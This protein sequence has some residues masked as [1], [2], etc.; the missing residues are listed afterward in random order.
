MD[1]NQIRNASFDDIVFEG[2]NKQYGAYELRKKYNVRLLIAVIFAG[3]LAALLMVL[4]L[5]FGRPDEKKKETKKDEVKIT[6]VNMVKKQAEKKQEPE[7]KPEPK[8]PEPSVKATI[9][10]IVDNPKEKASNPIDDKRDI[11]LKDEGKKDDDSNHNNNNNGVDP[12][13]DEDKDGTINQEDNCINDPGAIDNHGCPWGDSDQDGFA[14]NVDMCKTV[15]GIK[16]GDPGDGCPAKKVEEVAKNPAVPVQF[17]GDWNS[18]LS[19]TIEYPQDAIDAGDEGVVIVKYIVDVNGNVSEV[20]A[21]SGP[22]T[23]RKEAERAVKASSGK[24]T[25][26]KNEAGEF[27]KAYGTQKVN[28]KLE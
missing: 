19:R 4:F 28:F 18:Y 17:K 24:W 21:I 11:G 12:Y 10:K 14:D 9:P 20:K 23:L 15:K 7:K 5:F 1:I 16:G 22:T 3:V 2:R 13:G 27:I 8:K 6:A 26:G 25:P